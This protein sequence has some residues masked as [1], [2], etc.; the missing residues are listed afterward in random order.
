MNAKSRRS[1]GSWIAQP[2]VRTR[3]TRDTLFML[4]VI[5]WICAPHVGHLPVWCSAF[6]A[7]VL[8]W[9]AYL[10]WHGDKLPSR[11]LLGALLVV[12]TAATALSFN[13]LFG[14]N[15]GVTFVILLLSL[16]TLEMRARRDA[17]AVFFLGFFT[18][19]CNFL[20][21]QSPWS[22]LVMVVGVLGLLALL[23]N[24]NMPAG[25]PP[26]WQLMRKAG[27]MA[28]LGTPIMLTL[29]LLFPRIAPLW[30]VP[31]DSERART[32]LAND[33]QVGA[34]ASLA[35][36]GSIA[37]R[38]QFIGSAAPPSQS[39]YFR[40]PVLT[41]FDGRTWSATSPDAIGTAPPVVHT[42]GA[43]VTYKVDMFPDQMRSLVLLEATV[44]APTIVGY[45]ANLQSDLQWRLNRPLDLIAHFYATSF[46]QFQHGPLQWDR[47]LQAAMQLPPGYNPRTLDWAA[48]MLGEVRYA[49]ADNRT[50]ANAV[51]LNLRR[52]GY[53]YTLEPGLFGENSADEFWFDRKQ[54]FC[55]HIASAFVVM[56]RA[57]HVPAR[58]VTGYQGGEQNPLD[59]R[60]TVRHSDAH[61]WAEIWMPGEGWLRVDPTAAV[62]PQRIIGLERLRA[63][64]NIFSQALDAVSPGLLFNGRSAL[65]ALS[66]EWNQWILNYT[67]SDQLSL[68]RNVGFSEPDWQTLVQALTI[69]LSVAA[70]LLP[71][72]HLIG[73][74]MHSNGWCW[75]VCQAPR[76]LRHGHWRRPYS[77]STAASRQPRTRQTNPHGATLA[78]GFCGWSSGA[79]ENPTD[80]RAQDAA[81]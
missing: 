70:L 34:I 53:T 63:T 71:T 2:A 13:S 50:L 54:G 12:S 21:S 62:A 27:W 19:L 7:A 41:R 52:G 10:T 45:R 11:A 68:L 55:E 38:L 5:A 24:S 46:T 77:A 69:L 9:R 4:A 25:R 26:L 60:W 78:T 30:G 56:M 80:P 31:T 67:Q 36:D 6:T 48:R 16:K 47:S 17:Y 35:L 73:S 49:H 74:S 14:R 3:E 32:G 37:M 20:Y 51:L 57:L 61:A 23:I 42:Q 1:W 65:D 39:L 44:T 59:G 75:P 79:M 29:F 15:A 40:G 72:N 58:I 64:R 66:T 33:M 8:L 81:R 76:R 18:L 43:P 28:L 22:A